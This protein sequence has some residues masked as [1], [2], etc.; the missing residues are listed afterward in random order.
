MHTTYITFFFIILFSRTLFIIFFP[1]DGG[2]YEI[3]TT[4]ALNILNGCGVSLSNPL[5]KECIPHFGGNHGPGYPLFLSIV[6]SIFNHSD[7]AV[8][9]IQT[10]IYSIASLWLIRATYIL[11][12]NKNNLIVIGLLL[13]FS[14]LL[15][16]W[17][18]YVQTETLSIAATIFLLAEL[19]LSLS[20]KKIRI[21]TIGISLILATWIRLDNIFLTVPVALAVIYIHGFKVGIIKGLI[22]ALILFSTWGA[23]MTRNIIVELPSLL[24]TDMTMPDGSRSPTGYLKWTKTWITHEYERPGALWGINRKNYDSISIPESAYTDNLEKLK[25][26]ELLNKLENINKEDFPEKIDNEFKIIANNKIK[27]NPFKH[28]IVNPSIRAIRI[29]TNP[30]SSFGWP[31]EMP[32]QG[33]SKEERLKAANGNKNILVQKAFEYPIHAV[34]KALNAFYRLILMLLCLF[35]FIYLLKNSKNKNLLF[36]GLITLSY[37][38]SRTI[39]FSLNSNFET[40]YMVTTIPFIELFVVLTI[41]SFF[42]KKY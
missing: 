13:T 42:N 22:I 39:F 17:P 9:F 27:N 5:T 23:W 38:I 19:I 37:M 21:L 11:T 2:D 28:W 3:Y 35:G 20:A 40:R 6:W 10:I 31:N 14:P 8:R 4:V 16:A 24:P 41:F 30:F 34:S 1:A 29:W 7:Y 12:R 32:D 25:V 15:I 26:T 33:L 18:R 36:V